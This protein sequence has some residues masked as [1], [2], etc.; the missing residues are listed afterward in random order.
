MAQAALGDASPKL[1]AALELL[2][3]I[4]I[5]L[6]NPAEAESLHLRARHS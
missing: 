3:D 4:Q 5:R 1:A 2:G 6:A